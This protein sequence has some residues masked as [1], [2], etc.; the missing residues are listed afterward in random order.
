LFC[1]LVNLAYFTLLTPAELLGSPAVAI[2]AT[3]KVN[4]LN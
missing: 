1:S 2:T 4:F 3:A